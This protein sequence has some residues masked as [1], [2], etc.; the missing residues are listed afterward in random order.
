MRNSTCII[1]ETNLFILAIQVVC[2]FHYISAGAF[3]SFLQAS[4]SSS[5]LQGISDSVETV[6]VVIS[7]QLT[8]TNSALLINISSNLEHNL[9]V[10]MTSLDIVTMCNIRSL[11]LDFFTAVPMRNSIIFVLDKRQIDLVR[12]EVSHPHERQVLSWC[13]CSL[14]W[15]C[16][17][18]QERKTKDSEL[19]IFNW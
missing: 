13:S 14:H 19:N 10:A 4:A 2:H 16:Q 17:T 8:K 15:R 5:N 12:I 7:D 18:F 6:V 11:P 9:N 1:Q 3:S